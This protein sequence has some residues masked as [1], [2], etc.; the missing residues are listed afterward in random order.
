MKEIIHNVVCVQG[1]VARIGQEFVAR[2]MISLV[3]AVCEEINRSDIIMIS[4]VIYRV[5]QNKEYI[6][7]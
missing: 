1:E 4:I 7:Q 6:L 2:I 3:R 5:Y